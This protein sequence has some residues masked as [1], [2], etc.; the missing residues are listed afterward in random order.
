MSSLP[1]TR[2][3]A[4]TLLRAE[5]LALVLVCFAVVLSSACRP[6]TAPTPTLTTVTAVHTDHEAEACPTPAPS[7]GHSRDDWSK[8]PPPL[9]LPRMEE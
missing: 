5:Y 2:P 4:A 9:P 8:G 3:P 7:V 1:T 6:P